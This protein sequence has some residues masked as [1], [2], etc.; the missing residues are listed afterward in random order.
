MYFYHRVTKSTFLERSVHVGR[1]WCSNRSIKLTPTVKPSWVPAK[2]GTGRSWWW[3][4]SGDLSAALPRPPE[5]GLTS[6]SSILREHCCVMLF[7][8]PWMIWCQYK[9]YSWEELWRSPGSV[10]KCCCW[11]QWA[12][13]EPLSQHLFLWVAFFSRQRSSEV[14][15]SPQLRARRSPQMEFIGQLGWGQSIGHLSG[16]CIGHLRWR[17][18]MWLIVLP[19]WH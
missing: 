13:R 1:G 15:R 2:F 18:S 11:V 7:T 8:F 19:I 3:C 6:F 4:Y 14:L 17:Q 9:N 16:K 12:Q 5:T 10:P